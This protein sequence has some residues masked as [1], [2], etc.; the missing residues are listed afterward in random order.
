MG[1]MQM[2]M[3]QMM[4]HMMA[5]RSDGEHGGEPANGANQS[6]AQPPAQNHEAHH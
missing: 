1:M 6:E 4:E 5:Q 3:G 2:M